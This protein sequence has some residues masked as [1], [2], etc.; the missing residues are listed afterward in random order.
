MPDLK[1]ILKESSEVI[2]KQLE[3][4]LPAGKGYPPQL[5]EAL[6]YSIFSGGKRIRPVLCLAASRL[7]NGKDEDVLPV[8][9][10]IELIHT[11]SLIHD[12]LPAMDNDDMRR[13]KP[14]SHKK[15]GEA[16]AILA[17]DALLTLAFEL[18]C[19]GEADLKKSAICL[20]LAQAA[21]KDNLIGGQV[22][23]I[24]YENKE[25]DLPTLEY[26]HAHKTG[27]L[28]AVSTKA[29]AIAA[30]AGEEEVK[31]L[32]NY[33]EYL[34]F[35]FQLTDDLLDGEGYCRIL[36]P[37][38]IR[39]KAADLVDKAKEEL[40]CFKDEAWALRDLA[41]YILNRKY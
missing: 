28:I 7:C 30:G 34:G 6:R 17:G 9:C 1:K 12:D 23:D 31:R 29:G 3:L 27:A 11:Y 8:A 38:E 32:Y 13:G 14:A 22:M 5:Y 20:E 24:M 19:S 4:Y 21:G 15:Y 18:I 2:D 37:H 39:Q 40:S 41:D 16:V 26:I 25:L 10:A 33:G 36:S 35:V